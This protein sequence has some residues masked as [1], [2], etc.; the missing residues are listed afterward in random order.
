MYDSGKNTPTSTIDPENV[1]T[2]M[3]PA[4]AIGSPLV[5]FVM[6]NSKLSSFS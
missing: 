2:T 3:A 4:P 1:G 6:V 5:A